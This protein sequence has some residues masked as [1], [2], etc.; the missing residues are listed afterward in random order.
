[1]SPWL[2]VATYAGLLDKIRH[3]VMFY[4]KM[5]IKQMIEFY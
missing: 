2:P 5:I 3:G 1:M 4:V